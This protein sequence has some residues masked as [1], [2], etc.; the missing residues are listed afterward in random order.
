MVQPDFLSVLKKSILGVT[1]FVCLSSVTY[2]RNLVYSRV[3][4]VRRTQRDRSIRSAIRLVKHV[5]CRAWVRWYEETPNDWNAC[6]VG[7]WSYPRASPKLSDPDAH[8][9]AF[10]STGTSLRDPRGQAGQG[11]ENQNSGSGIRVSEGI[12]H[13]R[14]VQSRRPGWFHHPADFAAQGRTHQGSPQCF[15]E[16]TSG[17]VDSPFRLRARLSSQP[18]TGRHSVTFSRFETLPK[19]LLFV[20][21]GRGLSREKTSNILFTRHNSFVGLLPTTQG[22]MSHHSTQGA[23]PKK[24]REGSAKPY[25]VVQF[26]PAPPFPPK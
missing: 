25:L 12:L 18:K 24:K 7:R 10:Q 6:S 17:P 14:Q 13:L 19:R 11:P 20:T 23:E 4:P 21:H 26:H 15:A 8:P 1:G 9:L 3:W 5:D 2:Q 22:E 16:R